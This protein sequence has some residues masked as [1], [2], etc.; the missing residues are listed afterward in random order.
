MNNE[1]S[2][3]EDLN[4]GITQ[5]VKSIKSK[6][7]HTKEKFVETPFGLYIKSTWGFL[8]RML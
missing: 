6:P 3:Q 2:M 4:K 5:E 1:E 8:N 7:E